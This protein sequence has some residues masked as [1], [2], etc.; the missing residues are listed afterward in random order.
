MAWML[1][2]LNG[3]VLLAW[4]IGT[5]RAARFR[6]SGFRPDRAPADGLV[7]YPRLSVIV[8]ARNE[9]AALER[10]AR[11]LLALDYPDLEIVAVDD[12]SSDAT[13]AILDRLA[14]EDP[15]LRA[16]HV[17]D[18]PAGWLGKTHALHGG[19]RRATGDWLL[20][21]DADVQFEP[22]ALRRA[23]GHAV[24]AG[25][26]HLVLLPEVVMGGF[27][28]RVLVGYFCAMFS[29]RFEP[30]RVADPKSRAHIGVGAFNLV[31]AAAYR[32]AGGHAALR[33]DVLDDVKLGKVMKASGGR[34]ACGFGGG[35]VRVRWAKGVRGV[36]G[37]LQKNMF[38]GFGYRPVHALIGIVQTLLLCAWPAVGLFIGPWAARAACLGVLACMMVMVRAAP[39]APGVS[40]ILGLAYP[41]ASCVFCYAVL[42]SMVLTYR[43][44][45]VVWRGTLYPLAELRR[46]VV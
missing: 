7:R 37:N 44:G 42:R 29:F 24:G 20:F 23:V 27:W 26:D 17:R 30:W 18:L 2:L 38:A 43:H 1:S 16:V 13:G 40:P 35:L 11:T 45:G 46:G 10:A 39:A 32:K 3:L 4:L 14:A 15:R 19:S 28:E 9:E 25:I 31:R 22:T 34:Q 21:T 5:A 36:I 33:M 12:R 6:R 41:I 8:A